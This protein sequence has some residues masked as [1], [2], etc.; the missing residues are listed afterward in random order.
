MNRRDI[1]K[2]FGLGAAASIPVMVAAPVAAKPVTIKDIEH[3]LRRCFKG[4]LV[5][6]ITMR[7]GRVY[8][9][10]ATLH[11]DPTSVKIT[12]PVWFSGVVDHIAILNDN[13][14]AVRLG[15]ENMNTPYLV[16]GS[17]CDVEVTA[18]A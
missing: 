11:P 12:F 10:N 7:G 4:R 9:E 13:R 2:L 15:P 5:A 14:E 16:Q 17:T 3:P 18:G 8:R 6:R 1:M